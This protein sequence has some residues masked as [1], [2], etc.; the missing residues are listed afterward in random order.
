MSKLRITVVLTVVALAAF[1]GIASASHSWGG[2]HWARTANP[3]TLKVGDNVTSAW[4]GILATTS[5]DWTASSVLDTTIV[6]G[7]A[8]NVRRCRATD[9]RVE[10]CNST[11]GNTGWLGIASINITSGSHIT[12]GTVKLNDT[13]FNTSQ[14]N[15]TAWRNL[16]SC[17]EV[18][19]TLGLDH[20]DENF[21]NP[22]LGTCMDYT[23]NPSTNQ[24]PNS[25]DYQQLVTIYSHLDSF[26]TVKAIQRQLNNMPPAMRDIDFEGP[27]QWGKL[28]SVSRDGRQ[29]VFEQDFGRGYKVITH[30]FWAFDVRQ[31]QN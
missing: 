19:H 10:V 31:P 3:F 29:T 21:S 23:N 30:V 6:A 9:G 14:Y 2:Y 15:S 24:H 4:D 8:G 18:G 26:T 11:Y 12:S 16:V 7:G 13:Y 22:N 20:Q 5:S 25:H 17:Q 27:G 28:I 1:A